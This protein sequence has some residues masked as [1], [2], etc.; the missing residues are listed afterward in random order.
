[1]TNPLLDQTL[2]PDFQQ[3]NPGIVCQSIESILDDNR[4]KIDQLTSQQQF[5]WDSLA[6]PIEE[7]TDRLD[8]AW[9]VVSHMN[10]VMNTEELRDA[11]NESIKKVTE[12]STEFGQNQKLWSA[13]QTL[14]ESPEYEKLS[15]AQQQSIRHALRD[16]HLSGVD[17][18]PERKERFS[19]LSQKMAGLG[20]RFSNNVL[21]ATHAWT[22][23]ITETDRLTGIPENALKMAQQTAREKG[24]DGY[25]FTL[26]IPSYMPVMS[27]CDDED[28]RKQMYEAYVT[29]ASECGPNAGKWDNS[30][31]IED[32]LACRLELANILG[33]ANYA[34]RSLAKKMARSPAQVLDFLNEL[35]EKSRPHA[36]LEFAELKQYAGELGKTKL[37]AWDVAYYSEKLRHKLFDFSQ[38]DVRPY[39]PL[40]KALNGLFECVHRLF[41]VDISPLSDIPVWHQDVQVFEIK[42]H[43]RRIA[44]FYL[45]LYARK[46]KRGGAWMASCRQRRKTLAGQLQLPVAFLTCNFSSP[47]GEQPSLLTHNELTTLF[48]EFGHGLHHMLTRIEVSG[49]SGISGVAWDA[50]E[51]PS[52]FL[53]NWC[54]QPESLAEISGHYQSEEPLPAE[55]LDNMLKAK[56]FQ[57]GM[58]TLRQLEFGLFDFRLHHEYSDNNRVDILNLIDDVRDKVSILK[59]PAFNRF[60]HSF[61]HIFAGGGGYAAGYYSYKWAEVLAADAFSRFEEEGIFNPETGQA[62]KQTI[63]EQGGS[64]D[65]MAL[66]VEFRGRKP[67]VEP[68]LKQNG[69]L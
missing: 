67:E 24:L 13:F 68:L 26:D 25:V 19:T 48:H 65:P 33:F 56:N 8:N 43:G 18:A 7:L 21:D 1:M 40:P 49:V 30:E 59:P 46:N 31:I 38:E 51:L 4:K 50:V 32:I 12:Y 23:H 60:T 5:T 69:L 6:L 9:S 54:W 39:F 3:F 55:M 22:L 45:D 58:M 2:F 64:Q 66:F 41:D 35:A 34:E 57:A 62:F 36:E 15:R 53:E 11:Y 52:Q 42:S 28:I 17:L 16:F 29:R 44:A 63:L 47:V 37:E 20:S 61:N 14:A 10:G 27:Y